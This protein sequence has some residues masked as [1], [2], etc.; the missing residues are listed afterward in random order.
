MLKTSNSVVGLQKTPTNK[1]LN[2]NQEY[3]TKMEETEKLHEQ[4]REQGMHLIHEAVAKDGMYYGDVKNIKSMAVIAQMLEILKAHHEDEEDEFK[5]V[6]ESLERGNEKEYRDEIMKYFEVLKKEIGWINM[7]LTKH[8]D[9][10]A[11]KY[12]KDGIEEIHATIK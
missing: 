10:V 7:M 11:R 9:H 6:K 4:V 12:V 8:G 2:Q 1:Q 3:G 5:E